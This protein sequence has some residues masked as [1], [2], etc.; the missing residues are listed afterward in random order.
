MIPLST[1]W[2]D[3]SSTPRNSTGR[4]HYWWKYVPIVS[5]VPVAFCQLRND[6]HVNSEEMAEVVINFGLP[7]E[8]GRDQA[9]F[10]CV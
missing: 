5:I 7:E 3:R 9:G 8:L 1:R 2:S 10:H 4:L 6:A